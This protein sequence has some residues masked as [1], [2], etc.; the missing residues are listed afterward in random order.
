MI[1]A[2]GWQYEQEWRLIL[3]WGPIKGR[4]LLINSPKPTAIYIGYRASKDKIESLKEAIKG[5]NI[6]I[7]Q[8]KR[9]ENSFLLYA[10]KMEL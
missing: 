8:M 10:E 7:Y 9:Q 4:G 3:P 5:Q 2:E 1:K 6:P